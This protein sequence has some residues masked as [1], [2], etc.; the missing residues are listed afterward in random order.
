[1]LVAWERAFS[2]LF[3][4]PGWPTAPIPFVSWTVLAGILY[5]FWLIC[6]HD[7]AHHTLTSWVWFDEAIAR[8][9]SWPMLWPFGVY[10]E[11]HRLHHS[12]N[13]RDLRDPER[14]QW[15]VLEYR[16]ATPLLRWYIHH[17][18]W[19]DIFGSGRYGDNCQNRLAGAKASE[20]P[21]PELRRQL[22]LDGVGNARS[23]TRLFW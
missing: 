22:L 10:S 17:Q 12:W 15:T 6:T 4:S 18:W 2:P 9:I 11:L 8:L 23:Y 13:S 20:L 7:A 5:S 3:I 21:P 14:V 19:I 1:M 16:Q